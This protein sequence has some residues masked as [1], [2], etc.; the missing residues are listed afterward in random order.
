MTSTPA[1]TSLRA[2][3]FSRCIA[4][5]RL[6][7]LLAFAVPAFSGTD[8]PSEEEQAVGER[9]TTLQFYDLLSPC[10]EQCLVTAAYGRYVETNMTD[11]FSDPQ[12]FPWS[13]DY[14]DIDFAQYHVRAKA[15][16]LWSISVA[17][18]PRAER[19]GASETP[20][21]TSCGALSICRWN[22]VCLGSHRGY[23]HR[24]IDWGQ[25]CHGQ[26]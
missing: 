16:G 9:S 22:P 21:S 5:V 3:I 17:G 18:N 1:I 12:P 4:L 15:R 7:A 13:W 20:T 10:S 26:Q 11:I 23:V 19:E 8:S 6:F 2:S 24:G 14:G 25:L